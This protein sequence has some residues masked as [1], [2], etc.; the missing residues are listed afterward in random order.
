MELKY[1]KRDLKADVIVGTISGS[2]FAIIYSFFFRE[3]D[4]K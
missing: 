4:N 3:F 2:T 1:G